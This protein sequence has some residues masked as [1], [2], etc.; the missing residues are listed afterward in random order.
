MGHL[1]LPDDLVAPELLKRNQGW[2]PCEDYRDLNNYSIP[3]K[4]YSDFTQPTTARYTNISK[5]DLVKAY[6]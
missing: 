5:N 2:R 3:D 6:N 4:A 1:E